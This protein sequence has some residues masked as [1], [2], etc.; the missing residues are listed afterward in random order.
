MESKVDVLLDAKAIHQALLKFN[1]EFGRLPIASKQ[2]LLKSILDKIEIQ[3]DEIILHV[4]NP[5]FDFDPNKKVPSTGCDT[6]DLK[7][8]YRSSWG[9]I[10][11]IV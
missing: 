2:S 11:L 9:S 5:G 3:K 6:G 8:A 10:R 7:L 1:D 4:K